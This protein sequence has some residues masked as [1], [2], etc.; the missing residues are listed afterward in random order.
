VISKVPSFKGYAFLPSSLGTLA[1]EPG[2]QE[3]LRSPCD[4]NQE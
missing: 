4:I 3:A 1:L 2:D